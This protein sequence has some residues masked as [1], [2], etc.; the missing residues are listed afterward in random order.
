MWVMNGM[1]RT[2]FEFQYLIFQ[3]QKYGFRVQL[4]KR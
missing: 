1:G 2:M 4:S 3:S